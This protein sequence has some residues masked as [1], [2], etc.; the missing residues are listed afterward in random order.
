MPEYGSG[1]VWTSRGP[2]APSSLGLSEALQDD[3]S[4]WV[5]EWRDGSAGIDEESF[6]QWGRR[7]AQQLANELTVTVTYE[8]EQFI[9]N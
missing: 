7:L 1:P 3:L 4:N 6:Y 9:P 8:N 2:E 5:D